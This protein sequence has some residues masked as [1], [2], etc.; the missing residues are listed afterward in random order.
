ML[1][2]TE[3]ERKFTVTGWDFS[4]V[5]AYLTTIAVPQYTG[6]RNDLYWKAPNVDF[7]RLNTLTGELA[8]KV[9]TASDIT[10]RIEESVILAKED[11]PAIERIATLLHGAPVLTL[12]RKVSAFTAYA[13]PGPGTLF[14]VELCVY[15]IDG[16]ERVFFEVEA[17]SL[18]IIEA[19]LTYDIGALGK[20]LVPVC[21][22]I[23]TIFTKE[24]K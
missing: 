24:A 17:D 18:A 2:Q 23:F 6:R 14:E 12:T 21:E 15:Q 7:I 8:T 9:T 4:G 3:T 16:D 22:S 10:T 11:I 19:F 13:E 5:C 20:D 1:F